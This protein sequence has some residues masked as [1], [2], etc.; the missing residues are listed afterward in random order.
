MTNIS[1]NRWTIARAAVRAWPRHELA[2]RAQRKA[3]M[4]RWIAAVQAL[5]TR[6]LMHPSRRLQRHRDAAVLIVAAASALPWE[7]L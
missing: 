7:R 5:G 6:W 1:L 4:R 3:H 2:D